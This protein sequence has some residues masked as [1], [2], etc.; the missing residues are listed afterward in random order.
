LDN[1]MRGKRVVYVIDTVSACSW[2]RCTVPGRELA[3]RGYEVRVKRDLTQTDIEWCDVLVLQ[4]IWNPEAQQAI[5]LA[6]SGGSLTVF[7]IDDDLWNIRPNNPYHGFWTAPGRTQSLAANIGACALVTTTSEPL[8]A[9]LRTL[10]K[11]VRLLPNML[12]ATDWPAEAKSLD[13]GAPLV[14]GWAGSQTHD[15]DLRPVAA[16]T[17]Q[18][19]ERYPHVEFHFAGASPNWFEP[20]ERLRFL[21]PVAIDEYASL[22]S[23]FDIALAPLEDIRFNAG[24]SDLKVLESSMVGLPVIASKVPPYEASIKHGE[25]GFLARNPKDWLK[26]ITVLIEDTELRQRMGAAARAWAETRTIQRTADLWERA[27]G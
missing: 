26:H 18:I 9:K 16:L 7:D 13:H 22:I 23:D 17:A 25:T 1:E 2:Y 15:V 10:N 8:A 11:D 4:R 24:K 27:Y 14:V 6:R 5:A 19:L 12:S 3:D 20:H 21:E